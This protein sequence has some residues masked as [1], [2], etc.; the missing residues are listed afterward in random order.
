L[1]GVD[2]TCVRGCRRFW[3][4]LAPCHWVLNSSSTLDL[5]QI[6]DIPIFPLYRVE[7]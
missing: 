2:R 4:R 6:R 5:I 1:G 3:D 7:G